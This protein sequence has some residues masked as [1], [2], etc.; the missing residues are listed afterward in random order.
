MTKPKNS[1]MI[2]KVL[3]Q[4][5][6]EGGQKNKKCQGMTG[7]QVLAKISKEDI[8]SIEYSVKIRKALEPVF[9]DAILNLLNDL[10]KPVGDIKITFLIEQLKP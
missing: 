4:G 9:M 10:P 3:A 5:L 6:W 2:K 1:L 7:A 8:K